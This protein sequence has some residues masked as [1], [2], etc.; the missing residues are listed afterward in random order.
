MVF[1]TILK[2]IVNR[3]ANCGGLQ[4]EQTMDVREDHWRDVCSAVGEALD[5][6]T[7]CG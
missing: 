3:L 7:D 4:L 5:Q 6:I 1:R 2:P